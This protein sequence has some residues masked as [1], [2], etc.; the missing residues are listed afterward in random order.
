MEKAHRAIRFNQKAW[1]KPYIDMIIILI[2]A[3]KKHFQKDFIKLVNNSVF[4]KT[5]ENFQK[6]RSIK[7]MKIKKKKNVLGVRTKLSYYKFFH[8]NFIDYRNEKN[9][10]TCK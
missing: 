5:V 2:N 8:R 4:G 10:D 3:A 9:S 6:H 7:L 1:L